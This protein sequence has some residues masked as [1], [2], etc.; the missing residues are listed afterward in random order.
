MAF[1]L[2]INQF[3]G[4]G[5]SASW[6]SRVFYV[7]SALMV[8]ILLCYG[9]F[10]FKTYLQRKE[11][12]EI[13]EKIAF[14]GTQDQK[15]NEKKII[16]LQEKLKDFSG[17]VE[18]HKISTNVFS[19]IEQKTLPKIWFSSFDLSETTSDMRL[20]GIAENMEILS[21]QVLA[22]EKSANYVK[23]IN[24]LDS[25]IESSGKISFMINLSL[26]PKIFTYITAIKDN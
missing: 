26:D 14:Y 8:A 18:N 15:E 24:I 7:M 13:N 1:N 2:H 11:I 5:V 10:S 12:N 16:D 3:I 6:I 17:I 22:F 4:K 19:F 20:A 9:I 23:H 21:Q 25:Q